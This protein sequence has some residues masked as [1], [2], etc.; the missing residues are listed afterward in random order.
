MNLIKFAFLLFVLTYS[1]QIFAQQNEVALTPLKFDRTEHDF[2]EIEQGQ[3][4]N[5]EFEFVNNSA[6]TL[7]IK[8]VVASCGC[9]SPSW[10]KEPVPPKGTG[11]IK[12]EFDSL[13]KEG[14]QRKTITVVYN[15]AQ[16]AKLK[17]YANVLTQ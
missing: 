10:T 14:V 16:T 9:T 6:D 7:F 12:V 8:N 4:V 3:V 11:N 2:G 13:D 15:V 5:T 1:V 17:I